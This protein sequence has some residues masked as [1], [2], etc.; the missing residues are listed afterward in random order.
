MKQSHS[1]SV[2]MKWRSLGSA[3]MK[4]R[5]SSLVWNCLLRNF[6]AEHS[7]CRWWW[8]LAGAGND[9][10]AGVGQGGWWE[11]QC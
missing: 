1:G 6:L 11:L 4:W 5:V 10:G 8:E 7:W 3:D 9:G 2:D